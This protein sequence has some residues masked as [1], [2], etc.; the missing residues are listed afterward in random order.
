MHSVSS[1]VQNK[2]WTLP[3]VVRSSF[4][5][6]F[7]FYAF[8]LV[9]ACLD[10]RFLAHLSPDTVTADVARQQPDTSNDV[11]EAVG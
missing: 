11:A 7:G 1:L 4:L 6:W 3:N 2:K 10:G 8:V 9:M 5:L